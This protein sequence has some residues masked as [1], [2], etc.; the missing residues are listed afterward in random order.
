MVVP[1]GRGGITWDLSDILEGH[2]G[3]YLSF[4]VCSTGLHTMLQVPGF[5]RATRVRRRSCEQ[6]G[7]KLAYLVTFSITL[8]PCDLTGT[9]IY[10][11]NY[12]AMWKEKYPPPPP[13]KMTARIECLQVPSL[14]L[15][16]FQSKNTFPTDGV[17]PYTQEKHSINKWL[18]K[19][20][21]KLT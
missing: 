19:M 4:P 6:V 18:I 3:C 11:I 9:N 12:R 5:T 8:C 13:L 21:A 17:V 15:I 2:I 16:I 7:E 14:L 20:I 10:A 1:V